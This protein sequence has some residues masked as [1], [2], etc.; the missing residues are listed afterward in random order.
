MRSHCD[1]NLRTEDDWTPIHLACSQGHLQVLQ[2][3][4]HV[5]KANVQVVLETRGTPMQCA[6]ANGKYD[7]VRYLL[8]LNIGPKYL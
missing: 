7:I 2:T 8:F 1:P 4:I 5:G 6:L 3:I